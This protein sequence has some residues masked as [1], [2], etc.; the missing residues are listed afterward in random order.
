MVTIVCVCVYACVKV[1][2][3]LLACFFLLLFLI[4]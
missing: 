2:M 1:F 3:C 4:K